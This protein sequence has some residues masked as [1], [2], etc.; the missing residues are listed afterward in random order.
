MP[1][2]LPMN[3]VFHEKTTKSFYMVPITDALHPR[4]IRD[5]W[6]RLELGEVVIAGLLETH[7]QITALGRDV[8]SGCEQH[9]PACSP[10]GHVA[11]KRGTDGCGETLPAEGFIRG[12]PKD[13]ECADTHAI[14]GSH[15]YDSFFLD[16]D[17]AKV[18]HPHIIEVN[19]CYGCIERLVAE[20]PIKPGDVLGIV[21]PEWAAEFFAFL[22]GWLAFQLHEC[23]QWIVPQLKAQ[24]EKLSAG[25]F[26]A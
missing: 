26:G 9:A 11:N 25:R 1:F 16:Q 7:A 3:K 2:K 8:V 15:R 17:V 5:L 19:L 4:R 14:C 10:A 13:L 12:N 21:V 18:G 23:Q 20:I 22:M 6:R 24:R